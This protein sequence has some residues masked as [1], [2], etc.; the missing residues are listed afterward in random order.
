MACG[1]PV[2]TTRVGGNV[3][4]IPNEQLGILVPFWNA[5]E[6]ESALLEALSRK[7]NRDGIIAYARQHEWS[8]RIETLVA[9]LKSVLR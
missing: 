9:L 1:A 3:E 5:R 2:V 8:A 7:W 6:F 4:V